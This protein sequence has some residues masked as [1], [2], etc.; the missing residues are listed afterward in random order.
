MSP[1]RAFLAEFDARSRRTPAS[2][3]G[4]PE[5]VLVPDDEVRRMTDAPVFLCLRLGSNESEVDITW[6][7]ANPKSTGA[8]TRLLLELVEVAA[9]LGV[10]LKAI[11]LGRD[12]R[13]T[14]WYER[15]RFVRSRSGAVT[16]RPAPA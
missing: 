11:P 13:T 16:F 14:A 8:G 10:T 7:G 12:E 3:S 2:L 5:G 1:S 15:H 9:R 6:I 4:A